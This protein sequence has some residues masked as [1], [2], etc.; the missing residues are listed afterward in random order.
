[1]ILPPNAKTLD[2]IRSSFAWNIPERFNIGVACSNVIAALKP[3][4]PA[5]ISDHGS[6]HAPTILTFKEL[7]QKSDCFAASLLSLGIERGAKIAIMLPQGEAAAIAHLGI[8]KAGCIAVPFAMQFGVDAVAFRIAKA[9][10]AAFIGNTASLAILNAGAAGNPPE[11][12][13]IAGAEFEN[14]LSFHDLASQPTADFVAAD[15]SADDHA[16]M[17]FTSGTTGQPKG[18]LHAHRVLPGHLP[19]I[20]MAQQM[21]PQPGDVFWTPSDWAWAGGL[22]N[23]LLPALY[24]GVPVIAASAARYSPQWAIDVMARNAATNIFMPPTAIRLFGAEN[25]DEAKRLN[26]RAVG[27]AGEQLGAATLTFAEQLFGAPINEFYGQTECNTVLGSSQLFGISKPGSMGKPV[28][29]HTVTILDDNG[30]PAPQGETGQIAVRSPDPVMFTGYLHEPD[31]TADKFHHEWL[32][33]GD[34]AYQD[35]EGYFFF[36]G[37]NDDLITSAGYRIGPGEIEDC[38]AAHRAI[39]IAAVI[40]KPDRVRTQI[41]AAYVKLA[42]GHIPS[43]ALENDIRAFVKTRLS[44]HQYPR[45]I[46]FVDEIPLTESGKVI[47]RLFRED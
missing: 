33:T 40:G 41:I 3:D 1:M 13:I 9:Q 45:A 6:E 27:V 36:Q 34:R 44:A 12:Q 29:G 39:E 16:M 19:G 15:T 18:A 11:H 43:I 5:I 21:M 28:P 38:L 23:G 31:A 35:E 32:L 17:L 46:H 10:P 26:L 37:R 47:R 20:Q 30:V 2:E 42:H 8:Y 14:A 22:L 7:A 4:A 24:L 25:K